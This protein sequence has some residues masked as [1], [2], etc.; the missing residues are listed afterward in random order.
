MILPLRFG[1][2]LVYNS[3]EDRIV[4][5][6]RHFDWKPV[7]DDRITM[8]RSLR[9][10]C[11][12]CIMC[13]LG[14]KH[15]GYDQH[16]FSTMTPSKYM[17]VGQNPGVNECHQDEPFVGQAGI[18]FNREIEKNGLERK[19]FYITNICKCYTENNAKPEYDSIQK[20][21]PFLQMELAILN[22][23]FLITLGAISFNHFC[24][25]AIYAKALGKLTHSELAG[26]KIFAIYHPSPRNL[27]DKV[28]KEAFSRQV[29]LL[30]RLIVGLRQREQV[31]N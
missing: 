24:P 25:D 12:D 17:I 11:K 1:N 2:Y 15:Y 22:P 26:K 29:S 6:I 4:R 31:R 13:H 19:D 23:D 3:E 16:V 21:H 27:A 18:N 30:C 5:E 14:R 28:R 10:T 20:C 8:L 9:D 7:N